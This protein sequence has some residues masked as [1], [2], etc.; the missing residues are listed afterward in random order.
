MDDPTPQLEA[1]WTKR[2]HIVHEE[3]IIARIPSTVIGGDTL[4]R[5]NPVCFPVQ[6]GKD[7]IEIPAITVNV[8]LPLQHPMARRLTDFS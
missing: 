7:T 2:K 1:A 4:L 5:D 8:A 3:D 6:N